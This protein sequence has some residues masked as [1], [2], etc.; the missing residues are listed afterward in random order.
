MNILTKNLVDQKYK[1]NIGEYSY[2]NPRIMDWNEG[3]TLTIGKFCSI[4]EGVTIFLGGEHRYDWI[5]TYPFSALTEIWP[6]AKNI[7]GHP[8]T[9]G[10][11]IIENDVWIGFNVTIMSGV[12][13]HNGAVIGANSLVT[14]NV[15]PYSIVAGNPAKEIK[16]RFNKKTI[17]NLLNTKW[18]DWP[19]HK[20]EKNI[21]TLC[22]PP[23][24]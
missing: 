4:S 17:A 23:K 14:K 1:N 9:K 19:K 10:D 15:D 12:I 16:K 8:K 7:K 20:I 2:G 18:W 13:I 5:T 21:L 22:A 3:A 11:V 24:I 6:Q